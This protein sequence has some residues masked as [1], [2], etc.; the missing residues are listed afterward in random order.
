MS[1]ASFAGVTFLVS[2]VAMV[3]VGG[4][5]QAQHMQLGLIAS[6]LT[7]ILGPAVVA[8][9]LARRLPQPPR[10]PSVRRLGLPVGG[11]LWL[12]GT[13]AVLALAA[14]AVTGALAMLSPWLRELAMAY[15]QM[16]EAL[17]Y[18]ADPA[19]R[20]LAITAVVVFAPVCEEVLFRGVLLPLQR[21]PERSVAAVVLLNGALFSLLHLNPLSFFAL[22]VVGAFFAH[23]VVITG[24]L[25][26]AILAH[27]ALNFVNG[28]IAPELLRSTGFG[29]DLSFAQYAAASALLVPIVAVSWRWG[30]GRWSR[31][32]KSDDGV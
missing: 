9:L 23:V 30:A 15:E 21:A 32:E 7:C 17:M 12:V 2:L 16:F 14:N 13:A 22:L 29:A 27:A 1:N 19:T 4:A 5:M 28:V 10:F 24:S 8:W 25:W 31:A 18:P 26:P 20:L 3:L 6:E 11:A